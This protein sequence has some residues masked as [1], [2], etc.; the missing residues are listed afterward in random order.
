M[1]KLIAALAGA[2]ALAAI[3]ADWRETKPPL[4][5]A[6]KPLTTILIAGIA[7]LAPESD[8]RLLI[9]GGLVLSLAGDVCLMFEGDAAFI[10]GLSSFLLAHLV[11]MA[12]FL[13]GLPAWPVPWWV[14]GF[15]AYGAV[16]AAL[17]LP[18]AGKLKLPVL[19][20]GLVLAGMAVTASVRYSALQ[21]TGALLALIG[22][23]LFL[24]SDSALGTRKFV[25][26]YVGAQG[27]ILS[28]YWLSIGLIAAST[29]DAQ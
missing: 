2:S 19:L 20:Y 1:L 17:L 18:R 24:I 13:I 27:L 7:A 12:A 29:L 9:L 22:A 3:V 16:F 11:F 28:T 25:G 15:V 4:F 21:S 23:G 6:L 26:R 8:Y 5:L 14:L 10:G